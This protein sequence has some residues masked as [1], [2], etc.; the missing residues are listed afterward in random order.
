MNEGMLEVPWYRQRWPWLIISVPVA[1]AMLGILMLILAMR[2]DDGLVAEDYYKQ[3]LAINSV[4][5]KEARA[6]ELQLRAELGIDGQRI[7][8]RLSGPSQPVRLLLYLAHPTRAG[9]DLR[10]YLHK[11]Q[12][13]LYVGALPQALNGRWHVMLEDET[14]NWRLR[15]IRQDGMDH[16]YLEA[17]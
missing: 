17:V 8:L 16:L 13:G 12:P 15:N 10:I 6:R 5:D 7:E 4:L 14:G 2:S 3:G 9:E 1:S 11:T